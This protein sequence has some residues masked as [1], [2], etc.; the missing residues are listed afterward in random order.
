MH[1]HHDHIQYCNNSEWPSSHSHDLQEAYPRLYS[2]VCNVRSALTR[3]HNFPVTNYFH[4]TP[5]VTSVTYAVVR[6][7]APLFGLWV[8]FLLFASSLP[9][10]PPAR[11]LSDAFCHTA[12]KTDVYRL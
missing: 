2:Q 12:R 6:A 8:L 3:G 9:A 1:H 5:L 4:S 7:R 10:L 11:N